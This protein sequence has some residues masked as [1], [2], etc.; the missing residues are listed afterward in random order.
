MI[1]AAMGAG[2]PPAP[3]PASTPASDAAS[4]P[5]ERPAARPAERTTE[6]PGG[7][8]ARPA[9]VQAPDLA[10]HQASGVAPEDFVFASRPVVVFADTPDD[11]AFRSQL[12]LIARDAAYLA[13][14]DVVVVVDT[15]P[16]QQSAWRRKLRPVG[17]S[18]VILDKQGVLVDRKPFP[19]SAREIG[20]AIDKT[21]ESRAENA[22]ARARAG[23]GARNVGAE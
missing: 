23:V 21:P 9:A 18:L 1:V 7:P 10:L 16:A 17:F 22:R 13:Q 4:G 6:R 19:W 8:D 5:A 20:R 2:T 15:D 11:P 3:P 14:R 12:D